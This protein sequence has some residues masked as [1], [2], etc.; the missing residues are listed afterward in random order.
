M[1]RVLLVDD[2]EVVRFGLGMLISAEHDLEVVGTAA[3]GFE[4]VSLAQQQR[5]DVVLMDLSMPGKDGVAAMVEIRAADPSIGLLALT[6]HGDEAT[7]RRA[8]AAGADGYLLKDSTVD[9]IV[10]A[11]RSVSAGGNPMS[12]VAARVAGL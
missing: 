11:V 5:P 6:T 7:V 12:P 1:I 8:L 2:H 3:D 4:A 10:G 9:E